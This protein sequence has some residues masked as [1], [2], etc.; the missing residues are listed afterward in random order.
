MKKETFKLDQEEH[1]IKDYEGFVYVVRDLKNL[2]SY[3]GSRSFW[4]RKKVEGKKNK[5]TFES[6]WST[7]S[8][9]SKYIKAQ[10]KIRPEDFTFD[11]LFLCKDKPVMK[12]IEQKFIIA[13]GALESDLWL[14][15]NCSLKMLCKIKDIES[16]IKV[17][18][19]IQMS[20]A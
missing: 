13:M 14:N 4:S 8:T 10:Y 9:S 18:N 20:G 1:N 12:Y 19:V 16:R 5:K 15:E 17:V 3:I 7:Y 11:I 6:K 2:Q